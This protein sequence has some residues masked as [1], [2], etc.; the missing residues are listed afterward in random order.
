MSPEFGNLAISDSSNIL[1]FQQYLSPRADPES[2][3][4]SRF[5]VVHN[6]LMYTSNKEGLEVR[7]NDSKVKKNVNR[8]RS[9]HLFAKLAKIVYTGFLRI[10]QNRLV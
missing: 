7:F 6:I 4:R 8:E 2:C 10:R 5:T 3:S 1:I 9:L